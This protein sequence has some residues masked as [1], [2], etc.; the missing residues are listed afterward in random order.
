MKLFHALKIFILGKPSEKVVE[1]PLFAS[2]RHHFLQRLWLLPWSLSLLFPAVLFF[3]HPSFWATSSVFLIALTF[4]CWRYRQVKSETSLVLNL[5]GILAFMVGALFVSG[6]APDDA[7]V[8]PLFMILSVLPFTGLISLRPMFG[9]GITLATVLLVSFQPS[10]RGF[11]LYSPGVISSFLG[12]LIAS[13]LSDYERIHASLSE[14]AVTDP[15]TGLGNF[16]SLKMDF[17][18]YQALAQREEH[19]L[20]LIRWGF[21]NVKELGSTPGSRVPFQFTNYLSQCIRQGDGL[22][23]LGEREFISLH[24]KLETGADLAV[25]VQQIYPAVQVT[26]TRGESQAL[27]EVLESLKKSSTLSTPSV[28][29]SSRWLS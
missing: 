4:L 19:A 8:I 25:R 12:L 11:L 27:V 1:S 16:Y 13:V 9:L 24:P 18:R 10:S 2:P 22:Y 17:R 14:A 29:K 21:E 5:L 7:S 20:L 28:E 3:R 15:T 6:I 26:W 23:Y